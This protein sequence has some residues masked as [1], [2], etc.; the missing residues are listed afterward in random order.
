MSRWGKH[1]RREPRVSADVL[2]SR[3]FFF[4]CTLPVPRLDHDAS[5]GINKQQ[6][7][8]K[9]QKL[10]LAPTETTNPASSFLEQ[11]VSNVQ[12]E[13][14]GKNEPQF[15][16]E[17][18]VRATGNHTTAGKQ[19]KSAHTRV[20][21]LSNGCRFCSKCQRFA[22]FTH[23]RRVAKYVTTV[24]HAVLVHYH[25]FPPRFRPKTLFCVNSTKPAI[26]S[27]ALS[28]SHFVDFRP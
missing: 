12:G 7:Q 16:E 15:T 9:R 18:C 21:L 4:T 17:G 5:N 8:H 19:K 26:F 25:H 10:G 3:V 2:V 1:Q 20:W 14:G 24:S 28:L 6:Q 23:G 13:G 11:L 27:R 22:L